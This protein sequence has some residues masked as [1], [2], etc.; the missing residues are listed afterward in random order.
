MLLALDPSACSLAIQ[1]LE[2]FTLTL[3]HVKC[4]V[5]GLTGL[6]AL[7]VP[8]LALSVAMSVPVALSVPFLS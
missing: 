6:L 8:I 5:D 1:L 3:L 2:S 7:S 4:C